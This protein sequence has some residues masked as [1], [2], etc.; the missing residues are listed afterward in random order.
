M[1]RRLSVTAL[2]LVSLSAC[3]DEATT[4]VDTGRTIFGLTTTNQLVRFQAGTPGTIDR[5][6]AITGLATGET[7]RGIDFRT[8]VAPAGGL[9]GLG[10]S[11]RLYTIDTLTGVATALGTAAF[12]PALE[13]GPLGVDFN[14]AV[15]RFR[16]HNSTRQDLRLNQLTGTVA[17][18]DSVLTYVTTDVNSAATPR[19]V[20][21]AY[22][23]AR[24]NVVGTGTV[25]FA[26]DAAT[27]AVVRLNNP[28]DGRLMT[29]GGLGLDASDDVG[30]DIAGDTGEA[31]ATIR[32]A[33]G[34]TSGLY[35]IL[36][37]GAAQLIGPV[38]TTVPLVGIT[39]VP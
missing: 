27:D 28:N 22:T 20:G 10:S 14:P 30:F 18:V 31:L 23:N 33:T 16:V 19:V 38:G 6:V 7:L 3:G 37:S 36:V 24:P 11:S 5:T 32:T 15:D 29:V 8:G 34:T 9:Y 12:T 25:L 26:I 35:R 39:I 17:A 4:P 1:L 13:V 21:T 2:A